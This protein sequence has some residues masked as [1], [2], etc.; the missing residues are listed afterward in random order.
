MGKHFRDKHSGFPS[1]SSHPGCTWNILHVIKY[2]HW[3]YSK[4]RYSN[5]RCAGGTHVAEVGN[6]GNDTNAFCD[7]KMQYCIIGEKTTQSTPEPKT[8]VRTRIKALISEE[9]SKKKS[10]HH[11]SP[12]CPVRTQLDRRDSIHHL[13]P[14]DSAPLADFVL[15]NGSPTSVHQKHEDSPIISPSDSLPLECC[16]DPVTSDKSY[17]ECEFQ[18]QPTEN[19]T[20]IEEKLE[21]TKQDMSEQKLIHA[22]EF[23]NPLDI[24]NVNKNLLLKMGLSKSGSFPLPGSSG[25]RG[26]GSGPSKLKHMQEGIGF[27]AKE[28]EKFQFGSKSHKSVEFRYSGDFSNNSM[29]SKAEYEVDGI[30]KSNQKTSD[31]HENRMAI[32]R[33]K[34]LKQK[35][36][37]VIKESRKERHRITMDG[38]LHKIPHGHGFSNEWKKETVNQ[39][40][41]PA[42]NRQGKASPEIDYSV[43]RMRHMRRT[44][45]LNESLDRYCQLYET[46]FNREA[47][48]R[49]SGR[50]KTEE[51]SLPSGSAPKSLTRVHSSPELKSYIYQSEDSSDVFSSGMMTRTVVDGSVSKGSSFDEQK[52]LDLSLD[53][54]NRLQL[55]SLEESKVQENLLGVGETNLVLGDEVGSTS[56]IPNNETN[57]E[58]SLIVDDFGN[59]KAREITSQ[60]EDIEEDIGPS[61]EPIAQ[62]EELIPVS[63]TDS[64]SLKNT[65]SPEHFSIAEGSEVKA[66]IPS[67]QDNMAEGGVEVL[68]NFS[69]YEILHFEVDAIEKAEFD[70]V[71]DVLELSG[72][73][74]NE[75]LGTWNSD[76]Q[77]V[78][79][80]V[81]EEVEDCWGNEEADNCSHLL[82]FDLINEVLMEIY[83]RSCS[84][85]PIPLSCLSH[86]RALPAGHHVLKEVWALVSWY[87]S[88]RHKANLSEDYV[89]SKDLAKSDGW[90]NLQFETECVGLE[91]DDLIFDDLLDEVFWT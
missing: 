89:V 42:I 24:I 50:S 73:S 12:S 28:Q 54:E 5:K 1:E 67:R 10:K 7:D 16:E 4:R 66:G 77:P 6:S 34:D 58:G 49:T 91:L 62:L 59:L 48:H 3:R 19:H 65:T 15:D 27:H 52:N 85:C 55:D 64:N 57:A 31:M 35:I 23:L 36:R 29:Q 56:S 87:M 71:R 32:K 86:I 68:N 22:K 47:K 76:E 83:G 37:H 79:P 25:R 90:M 45:S 61:K 38:I 9:M 8:S 84:Y 44:S 75:S 2:H 14:S 53:S 46:S 33:F 88:L 78:D 80:L 17:E 41:D 70:Y 21:N 39:L 82:L 40:K 72:F 30:L 20:L 11:R 43:S 81:Y 51:A 63:L 18:E 26:S 74:G 69:G 13:E 60:N